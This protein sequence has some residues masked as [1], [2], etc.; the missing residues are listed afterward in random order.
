M[1]DPD[2]MKLAM[3]VIEHLEAN[4]AYFEELAKPASAQPR[5]VNQEQKIEIMFLERERTELEM[6]ALVLKH[7]PDCRMRIN[8]LCAVGFFGEN[9]KNKNVVP[10]R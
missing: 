2:A 5:S 10:I 6:M 8:E 1:A 7:R 3:L 9:V 4:K